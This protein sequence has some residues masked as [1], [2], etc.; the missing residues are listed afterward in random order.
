MTHPELDPIDRLAVLAAALPG[1]T[2]GQRRIAAPFDTVWRVI[3]DLENS[4]PRYEPGVAQV[5]VIEQ[6]GEFLRVLVRDTAGGEDTM[7]ARLRPGWC[8][9][10]SATIVIAFA[11]RRV[12][13]ETLLAHL[14]HQRDRTPAPG[15]SESQLHRAALAK[16]DRELHTIEKLATRPEH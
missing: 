1:A 2:V 4:T 3:A 9:M 12:G 5:R 14:E 6:R 15:P 13:E 8:L 10:Q 7:D 11:A 16:I